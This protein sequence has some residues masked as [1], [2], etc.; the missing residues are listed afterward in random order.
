MKRVFDTN[1]ASDM[2]ILFKLLRGLDIEGL[3]HECR[4]EDES[5]V[6]EWEEGSD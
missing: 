3:E 6:L 2:F 5:V 4:E 1:S